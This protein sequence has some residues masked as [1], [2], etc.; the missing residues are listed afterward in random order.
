MKCCVRYAKRTTS[1][2]MAKPLEMVI[3]GTLSVS[4]M[5]ARETAS[6]NTPK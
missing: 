5:N 3:T 1:A 2:T 6:I 4:R